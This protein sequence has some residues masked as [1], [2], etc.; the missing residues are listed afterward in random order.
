MS[1]PPENKKLRYQDLNYEEKLKLQQ[2]YDE[3]RAL[4]DDNKF[5]DALKVY[6]KIFEPLFK[7]LQDDALESCVLMYDMRNDKNGNCG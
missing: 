1:G 5:V 4:Q 3:A 2:V 6:G 7:R